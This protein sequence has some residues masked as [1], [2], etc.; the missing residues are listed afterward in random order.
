RAAWARAAGRRH[1]R[2]DAAGYRRL[3]HLPADPRALRH[4]DPDADRARRPHGPRGR[5]RN[6]GRRL[7]A[8][9]IRAARAFGATAR[10][11][12]PRAGWAQTRPAALRTA[13]DRPRRPRGAARRHAASPPR[14]SIPLA[15]GA[16]PPS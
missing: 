13:R 5:P 12:P 6:G 3:G 4:S 15:A 1:P 8:E 14:L 10:D 11:P 16:R 7:F 9:T 2:P